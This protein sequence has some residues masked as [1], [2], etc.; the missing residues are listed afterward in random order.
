VLHDLQVAV[1][2]GEVNRRAPVSGSRWSKKL[3]LR[4]D[5]IPPNSPGGGVGLTTSLIVLMK[6]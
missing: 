5:R 1:H 3:Y 6:L 4:K 2:G